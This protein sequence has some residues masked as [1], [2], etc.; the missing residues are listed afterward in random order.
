MLRIPINY[1]NFV[2]F[3]IL[4][5]HLRQASLDFLSVK[6][7]TDVAA[8]TAV[9]YSFQESPR[10]LHH[11]IRTSSRICYSND[12]AVGPVGVTPKQQRFARVADSKPSLNEPCIITIDNTRYNLTAWGK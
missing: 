1:C 9:S 11:R 3:F 8:F 12:E 4:Y 10:R 6:C 2:I 7:G 5:D